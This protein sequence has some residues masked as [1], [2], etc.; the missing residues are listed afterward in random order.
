VRNSRTNLQLSLSE[1]ISEG[2]YGG[3][4]RRFKTWIAYQEVTVGGKIPH[5]PH[6]RI[7]PTDSLNL[8]IAVLAIPSFKGKFF[9]KVLNR[10]RIGVSKGRKEK[11]G[12]DFMIK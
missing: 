4:G 9:K 8:T 7:T 12:K 5:V 1:R 10:L 11:K 6:L 3:A 2:K